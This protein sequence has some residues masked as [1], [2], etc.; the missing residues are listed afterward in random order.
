MPSEHDPSLLQTLSDDMASLRKSV[1]SIVGRLENM[2]R[3]LAANTAMT[4][5]VSDATTF[6]RV[7]TSVVKWVGA[8]AIAVGSIFV[9]VKMVGG[10]HG[11]PPADIGPK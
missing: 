10:D 4:K 3:E 9:G 2:Q 7:G 1:E 8:V 11:L 6:V 5:T